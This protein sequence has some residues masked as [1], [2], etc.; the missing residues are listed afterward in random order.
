MDMLRVALERWRNGIGEGEGE[1]AVL[2]SSKFSVKLALAAFV[3]HIW[4]KINVATI[5][6]TFGKE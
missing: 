6:N 2:Y 3:I 5:I 1:G 4:R